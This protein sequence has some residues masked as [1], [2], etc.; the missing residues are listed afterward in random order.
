VRTYGGVPVIFSVDF[1]S[2]GAATAAAFIHT[3][4]EKRERAIVAGRAAAAALIHENRRKKSCLLYGDGALMGFKEAVYD[5][6]SCAHSTKS[7]NSGV[8]L[9]TWSKCKEKGPPYTQHTL[10]WVRR[11]PLLILIHKKLFLMCLM[12]IFVLWQ[13][14]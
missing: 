11:K 3:S 13:H 8:T 4:R 9:A 6:L 10:V 1:H 7:V 12:E 5:N 2:G 14:R